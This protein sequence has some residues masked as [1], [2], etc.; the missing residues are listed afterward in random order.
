MRERKLVVNKMVVALASFFA[1]AMV[2]FPDV[3]EEGSKTAIIIWANSIVPVLL[4]FF[5]FSDFIKRTGDLQ[6]LPPRVYPFIM[7]VLSGY[8]MGAKVVGDYVKEERLSLDEGRW[9]L[10]YSMVTG[11]AFILFTI[12]Q[13]IGSSKAAV[14]VAIAHYA[15]GI[16]N[17]L[18][19]ANKKGK[20]H[21]VQAAE[22]KPK[23]DY[24]EN[25]TYAIMG[26]FKSMAIILA[27]LIIFTIGINLLD[28]AGLFAAINDKTLCSC[29]KGFME[30]TVGI[31]Q[32]GM[33]NISVEMKTVLAAM[34]VSFGGMS[35]VGQSASMTRKT[36]I[37]V[38]DI[39]L[40]KI[41]HGMIAAIVA[42]ILGHFVV[43]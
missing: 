10:S 2:A 38:K 31:N 7:A 4:P 11:P 28:K 12:G 20:P 30:M 29:I 5:I 27:Y 9:V 17:G 21:K 42:V 33:C 35:I 23:G 41:T 32:M 16:L 6:K 25:F 14:L 18:L 13:F 39:F 19:Y 22:F 3:T 34:M 36:G 40:M 8:P 15:G 26:G 24:M 1:F 43:L 37:G